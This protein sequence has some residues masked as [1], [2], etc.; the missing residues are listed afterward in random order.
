LKGVEQILFAVLPS[1]W[2]QVGKSIYFINP[3]VPKQKMMLEILM[4]LHY[5]KS[6]DFW[7]FGI[8]MYEMLTGYVS[9]H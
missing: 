1:T 7:T 5:D 8:L 3:N 9:K 4:E 6:V 2:L